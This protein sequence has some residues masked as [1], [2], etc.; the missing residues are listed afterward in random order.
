MILF[1]LSYKFLQFL[2]FLIMLWVSKQDL[3]L[4][5]RDKLSTVTEPSENVNPKLVRKLRELRCES[6]LIRVKCRCE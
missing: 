4:L 5:F 3:M 2:A 6:Y 1:F